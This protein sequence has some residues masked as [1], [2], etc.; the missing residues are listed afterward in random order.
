[1]RNMPLC[2]RTE[3]DGTLR[4]HRNPIAT[5]P[6]GDLQFLVDGELDSDT[7]A[8]WSWT[9]DG[10]SSDVEFFDNDDDLMSGHWMGIGSSDN[11]EDNDENDDG[12]SDDDNDGS[13]DDESI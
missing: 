12:S 8:D 4:L 6:R 1:M 7:S 11:K 9:S 13:G 2:T 5:S 10:E 3:M